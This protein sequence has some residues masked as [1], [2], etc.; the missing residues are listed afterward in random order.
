LDH[1]QDWAR[2]PKGTS[3]PF[4]RSGAPTPRSRTLTE[5][6]LDCG[7]GRGVKG[8]EGTWARRGRWGEGSTRWDWRGLSTPLARTLD[9]GLGHG[10]VAPPLHWD[11]PFRRLG[12]CTNDHAGNGSTDLT[13][14]RVT[15]EIVETRAD[16]GLGR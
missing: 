5:V 3:S 16:R 14:A 13:T 2:I 8:W 1:A 12:L 15:V 11:S 7:D 9:L 4:P 10:R 6:H